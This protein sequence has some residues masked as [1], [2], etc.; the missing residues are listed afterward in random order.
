MAELIG[1]ILT[2]DALFTWAAASLVYK[3]GLG[4]TQPKANLFFRLCC[5]SISTFLI[6]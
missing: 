5:V 1:Y 2:L 3:W 4:K 6:S